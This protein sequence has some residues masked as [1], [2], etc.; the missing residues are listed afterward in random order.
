[1]YKR[2][3]SIYG[4]VGST[5]TTAYHS[6]KGSVRTFTK[7]VAIQYAPDLIRC[8]SVHPGF[9]DTGMTAAVHADP[10]E[11]NKRVSQTPIGRMG[12]AEDIAWGCVF[13]GSDESSFMTGAELVIDGGMTAQ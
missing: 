13:L 3:S 5:G 12:T 1:M 7:A 6:A 2:Q 9:A 8:N 4:I 11:W 10:E